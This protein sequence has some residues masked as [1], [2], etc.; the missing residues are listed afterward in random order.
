[1]EWNEVEMLAHWVLKKRFKLVNTDDLI[2][3]AYI[4]YTKCI[5][6]YRPEY[7]NFSTYYRTCL[8]GHI[9]D[10]LKYNSRLVHVPVNKARS[11]EETYSVGIDEPIGASKDGGEAIT[12]LDVLASDDEAEDAEDKEMAK[13]LSHLDDIYESLKPS[14]QKVVPYFKRFIMDGT[15]VPRAYSTAGSKIRTKLLE[16]RN[17]MENIG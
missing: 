11:G 9:K 17:K 1:M 5:E 13:W 8:E 2:G 10:Y 16:H 3:E 12:L 4:C 14:E 6:K 7:N 15:A